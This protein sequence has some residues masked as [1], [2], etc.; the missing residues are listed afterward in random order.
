MWG[1]WMHTS[2]IPSLETRRSEEIPSVAA[3]K[4]RKNMNIS[5]KLL[6]K[7][8]FVKVLYIWYLSLYIFSLRKGHNPTGQ[9]CQQKAHSGTVGTL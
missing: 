7:M 2:T 8:F 9:R 6:Q 5:D 4:K 3:C 1:S